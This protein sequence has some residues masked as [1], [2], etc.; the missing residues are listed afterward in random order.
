MQFVEEYLEKLD[1]LWLPYLLGRWVLVGGMGLDAVVDF[2]VVDLVLPVLL[3]WG[4][5]VDVL[6]VGVSLEDVSSVV[7]G[8]DDDG[9]GDDVDDND[10]VLIEKVVDAVDMDEVWRLGLWYTCTW[11]Q[12]GRRV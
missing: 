3:V 9:F 1:V 5:A 11:F 7:D 2:S 6:L 10:T 8:V 12:S 4:N